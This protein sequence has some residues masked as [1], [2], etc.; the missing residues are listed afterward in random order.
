MAVQLLFDIAS[1]TTKEKWYLSTG[2]MDF[3]YDQ[4]T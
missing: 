1:L 4:E 2:V 3:L